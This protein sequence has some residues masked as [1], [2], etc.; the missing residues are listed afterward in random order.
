MKK[1]SDL[2]WKIFSCWALREGKSVRNFLHW[3][4]CKNEHL[5]GKEVKNVSILKNNTFPQL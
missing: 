2:S 1:K 3:R 5:H 4:I